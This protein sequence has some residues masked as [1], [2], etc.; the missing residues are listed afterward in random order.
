MSQQGAALPV[1]VD[2]TGRRTRLVQWVARG[3][4]AAAVVVV[5]A[6]AFTL[7]THVPLPGLGGLVPE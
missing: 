5:G 7:L 3:V 6:V 2:A 4:C 1:F